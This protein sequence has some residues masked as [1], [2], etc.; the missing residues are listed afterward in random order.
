MAKQENNSRKQK[1]NFRY[2]YLIQVSIG[3]VVLGIG[4]YLFQLPER[5]TRVEEQIKY[6]EKRIDILEMRSQNI[7]QGSETTYMPT[8]VNPLELQVFIRTKQSEKVKT[9]YNENSCFTEADLKSFKDSRTP[10]QTVNE[11]MMDNSFFDLVIVIKNMNPTD[12]QKLLDTSSK[13]AKSSWTTMGEISAAG[14]TESG[15]E[16]ELLIANAIVVKIKELVYLSVDEINKK[17]PS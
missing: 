1:T 4:G 17:R 3:V 10:D 12:R 9:S 15:R 2:D 7:S 6:I 16:A 8:E 13:M 11:L 5:V 14:Q